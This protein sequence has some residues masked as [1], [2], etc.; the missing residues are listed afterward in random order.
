MLNI[1]TRLLAQV[2]E[3][4]FWMLCH[5][6]KRVNGKGRICWPANKTLCR[7]TGWHIEKLQRV[8]SAL[9]EKGFIE[10]TQRPDK[11]NLYKINTQKISVFI[12]LEDVEF[13]ESEEKGTGKSDIHKGTGKSGRRSTGKSGNK[14]LTNEVLISSNEGS[15]TKKPLDNDAPDEPQLTINA[16]TLESDEP[17]TSGA[18][19]PQQQAPQSIDFAKVC[20]TEFIRIWCDKYP[21]ILTMKNG[22]DGA[23]IKSI[24]GQVV[25][26]LK[27][28]KMEIS[29]TTVVEL[30][31]IF[32][33]NLHRT[34]G[35][36]KDLSTID[37]KF[38]SLFYELKA[39]GKSY[40][41][42]RNSW[43]SEFSEHAKY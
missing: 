32:V 20:Y 7:D 37:S 3:N 38:K 42:R 8:K 33:G 12:N 29:Q 28:E 16:E 21:G 2:D 40:P 10:V 27:T 5:L 18:A 6:A 1:D 22:K 25:E 31:N 17:N 11:T 43:E 35:H 34:W 26:V 4:E 14:V 19:R 39:G 36:L 9:A 24:I 41:T 13:E 30:W 15:D 23:K